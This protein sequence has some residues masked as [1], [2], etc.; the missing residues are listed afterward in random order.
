MT[1]AET[2]N[3]VKKLIS[4]HH[5]YGA[6]AVVKALVRASKSEPYLDENALVKL[7][8]SAFRREDE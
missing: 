3:E 6:E 7:V 1:I 2:R 8:H 4:E 5:V